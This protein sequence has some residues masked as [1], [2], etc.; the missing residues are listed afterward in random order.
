MAWS[1]E[2]FDREQAAARAERLDLLG[3]EDGRGRGAR[4]TAGELRPGA[5]HRARQ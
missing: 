1:S 3:P 5:G 4:S 2:G